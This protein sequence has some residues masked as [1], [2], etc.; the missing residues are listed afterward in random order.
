MIDLI[1]VTGIIL[2]AEPIGE[3]DRRVVILTKERGKISAFAK[4]ARKQTSTLLAA[5]APFSFG[6]FKIY[7]G[8]SSYTLSE[9]KIENYFEEFRTAMQEAF[10][11]MYF[12]EIADY[13]TRENND[14]KEMLKL[15]YA[16]LSALLKKRWSPA[17]VRCV[18]ELKA[19]AVNGEYPGAPEGSWNES[20]V[21]ALNFIGET[22]VENLYTFTV[23]DEVLNEMIKISEMYCKR[24]MDKK[25]KSVALLEDV[26]YNI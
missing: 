4:G 12:L 16:S 15:L 17:F 25:F 6:V 8:R 23:K 7:E 14:E 11:G 9:A 26:R 22:P 5:T 10:Y 18:Y 20:T 13:Y 19:I 21:Y 3:Y 1:P 2:K 24:Y